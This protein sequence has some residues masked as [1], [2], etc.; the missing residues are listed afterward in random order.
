VTYLEGRRDGPAH[1]YAPDGALAAEGSYLRGEREGRWR[2]WSAGRLTTGDYEAGRRVG[3]WRFHRV[4]KQRAALL[5]EGGYRHGLRHGSWREYPPGSAAVERRYHAGRLLGG[6]R[7]GPRLRSRAR[8]LL[9]RA[10][11]PGELDTTRAF[12]LPLIDLAAFR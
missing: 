10:G 2:F 4:W 3:H 11:G 1:L 9:V 8:L 7:E 6:E 5:E 12:A